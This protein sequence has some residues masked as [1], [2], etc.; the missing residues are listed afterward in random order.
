M[1]N[2]SASLSA[3]RNSAAITLR[4]FDAS[5]KAT[6]Q[7]A[8]A[9]DAAVAAMVSA[10]VFTLPVALDVLDRKG[11]IIE[12]VKCK[13][14]NFADEWKEGGKVSRAKQSAM[15]VALLSKF[16]GLKD[17]KSAAHD[18]VFIMLSRALHTARAIKNSALKATLDD[19]GALVATG[20]NNSATAKA[21]IEAPS[22]TARLAIAKPSKAAS[23]G[24]DKRKEES[25]INDNSVDLDM[26]LR[27]VAAYCAVIGKGEEEPSPARL[28]FLKAILRDCADTVNN[29]EGVDE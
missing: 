28:S 13:V 23:K 6:E 8:S 29:M 16:A 25:A 18:A 7:A 1:T 24:S 20:K 21:L 4:A 5:V 10:N 22:A 3:I 2:T 19:S 11:D 15:R 14:A 17:D 9:L 26:A 27:C 12:H